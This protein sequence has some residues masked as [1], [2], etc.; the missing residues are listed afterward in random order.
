MPLQE[1]ENELKSNGDDSKDK[2]ETD[3]KQNQQ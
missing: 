2:V 1:F 3:R